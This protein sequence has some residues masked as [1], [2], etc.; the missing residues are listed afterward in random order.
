MKDDY[1]K[2]VALK[3]REPHYTQLKTEAERLGVTVSGAMR[4]IL[5]EHLRG[6]D[7]R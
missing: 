4:M 1:G 7:R 6:K 2:L 5:L 3:L